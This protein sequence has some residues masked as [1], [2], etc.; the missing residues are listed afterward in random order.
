METISNF[1][2][3]LTQYQDIGLFLMRLLVGLLFAYSGYGKAKKLKDFSKHNGLP[4]PIGTLVVLAELMGGIGLVLGFLT[5][6]A[7]LFIMIVMT[8]SMFTHI[9]KWKSPYWA[10]KGG[11][12]YDLMWFT[13][14]LVILLSGGGSIA[15]Y[16]AL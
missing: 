1:F 2:A 13:M 8:G 10:S 12:E 9:F 6:I 5:Q 14:C 7:A 3:Q 11:W 15:L 16:P 4:L